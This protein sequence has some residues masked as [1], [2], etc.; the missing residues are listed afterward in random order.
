[1]SLKFSE[2]IWLI[3]ERIL[4]DC[5]NEISHLNVEFKNKYELNFEKNI[6]KF[7]NKLKEL[8]E[9]FLTMQL[10]RSDDYIFFK[11]IFDDDVENQLLKKSIKKVLE[12]TT[13]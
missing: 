4:R 6:K 13:N 5:W 10:I 7:L 1:M 12:N 9:Y 2:L 11:P 8:D 3:D